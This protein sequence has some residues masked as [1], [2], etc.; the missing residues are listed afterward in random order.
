MRLDTDAV[1]WSA[2]ERDR[3]GRPLIVLLHGYGSHEGDLFQLS[4][5]LPLAPVVASVRAPISESG[6]WAWFS[7]ARRDVAEPSPDDANG[8]TAALIEWL[9]TLE[10]TSVALLG[11]S[12]GA[13]VA[14]QAMR[15]KPARF[16]SVV[17]L[18]GF[19]ATGIEPG[20]SELEATRPPVFWGRGTLDAI[21]PDAVI[22]RTEDWLTTHS[23]PT[24]RI[25]ENLAHGV[26]S[27]ELSDISAFL[28]EHP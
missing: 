11:F 4:P 15:T 18:S 24:I 10:F 9:D 20:D 3:A 22:A 14:L 19:V 5:R 2:P 27:D 8:A 25:Y 16:T 13:V 23:T 7:L 17:A 1:I 12:Q 26:S 21:I 28:Q 6:G